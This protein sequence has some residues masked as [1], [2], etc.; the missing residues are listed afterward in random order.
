MAQ[1]FF[2]IFNTLTHLERTLFAQ[3]SSTHCNSFSTR[4]HDLRLVVKP[5]LD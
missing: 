2:A 3:S 5:E 4:R 1:A